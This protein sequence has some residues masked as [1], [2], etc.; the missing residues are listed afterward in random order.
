[1]AVEGMLEVSG[2][3]CRVQEGNMLLWLDSFMLSKPVAKGCS[4]AEAYFGKRIELVVFYKYIN[5]S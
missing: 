3:P 5:I 1:M 2:L 4:D